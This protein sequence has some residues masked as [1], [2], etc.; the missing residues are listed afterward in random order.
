[1]A[2]ERLSTS[3]IDFS[4]EDSNNKF[5][6]DWTNAAQSAY[7]NPGITEKVKAHLIEQGLSAEEVEELIS[8]GRSRTAQKYHDI[9]NQGD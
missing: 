8:K 2:Q 7:V 9:Q 4:D 3:E 1:M 6:D 5:E